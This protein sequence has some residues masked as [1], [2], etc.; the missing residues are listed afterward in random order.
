MRI[1]GHHRDAGPLLAGGVPVAIGWT[2]PFSEERMRILEE[3]SR[4]LSTVAPPRNSVRLAAQH[5][6]PQLADLV[7]VVVQRN[8]SGDQLEVVH[9]DPAEEPRIADL[10]SRVLPA[11]R[12][13]ARM[14]WEK[15]RQFRWIPDVSRSTTRFLG[16]GS[17]VSQLL[18][19]LGVRSLM[20][21]PLRSGGRIFGGIAFAHTREREAFRAPDLAVAQVIAR[22]L[23]VAIE[24]G[25]LHGRVQ[26]EQTQSTRIQ[27]ALQK[28][29]RVFDLAGWGA[30]IVDGS[31]QRIE[32]VNPA[33]ARL[34]GYS[35][36]DGLTGR[37]FTDLLPQDRSSEP[38]HWLTHRSGESRA[39]ESVHLRAD[40]TTFPVLTD[41]TQLDTGSGPAFVVT[42]QDL[43]DLKRAEDRLRRAQRLEA[44]GRLAGGVAHEVNNM[45]TIIL[46]FSD[47]L[48]R[49]PGLPPERLRDVEEIRKA[50]T[51]A[52]KTTQQLL[53]FSRQQI[54]QP[55]DL[56][57]N[58]IV[59]DLVPVLQLLLPA[60]ITVEP[61]LSPMGAILRADRAQLDQVLINLAFNAR[62]A[63]PGGGTL[64]LATDSRWLDA[65]AGKRLIGIPIPAGQYATVSVIDTG[66]GMD[67]ATVTQVF[68]PFFTTKP[69]GSGTGLGLATVYGIVKQSGG[70]VWV[71]ST[72]D[73]GTTVTIALPQVEQPAGAVAG[74]SEPKGGSAECRT[75]TVLVVEDEEGVRELACRVLEQ[76]GHRVLNAS[77]GAEALKVLDTLGDELDLVVSDVIVPDIAT[78][79]FE[80]QVR[81]RRPTLPILYM[82]GYSREEVVERGLI[83]PEG[84]FLQ[85]PFTG[86][87][88]GD[89]VYRALEDSGRV[90][91]GGAVTI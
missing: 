77:D 89:L 56:Q 51:R 78:N 1:V 91:R 8:E 21:V 25:E 50:A 22:R 65:E 3:V 39:Y 71:E 90:S 49:S 76:Q 19:S 16:T 13:A 84:F 33:F 83:S 34:H 36:P 81:R 47:L 73:M 18:L 48:S 82:S 20:V 14:D 41:V 61:A 7:L 23:A 79:E 59:S 10:V 53:A 54:L 63:M 70:Y 28:W 80:R 62:D 58:E 46:G 17:P 74:S 72:P 43:T 24:T 45:M 66:H 26:D 29:T 5:A 38:V 12:E 52:G 88:L 69:I 15:G 35:G 44:V 30:A 31:D 2:P 42:I 67:E 85:K 86:T 40:G 9:V 55:A 87:E 60:N 6:V 64:K 11:I 37:L 68:E 27:Q 4:T 75:G 32:A 57:V